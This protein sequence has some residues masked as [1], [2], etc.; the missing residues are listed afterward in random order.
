MDKLVEETDIQKLEREVKDLETRIQLETKQENL[1]QKREELLGKRR[2]LQNN[3][4]RPSIMDIMRQYG[5][6]Y[7]FVL[8]IFGLV[9]AGL[10]LILQLFYIG[11]LAGFCL[12]G[13][14]LLTPFLRPIWD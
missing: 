13:A 14:I 8:L 11:A 4:K 2:E 9:L 1:L 5:Y 7:T 12:I 10:N 6:Q 3:N